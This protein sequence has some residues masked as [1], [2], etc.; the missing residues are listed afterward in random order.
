[1]CG[2][3]MEI[4]FGGATETRGETSSLRCRARRQKGG[5]Q[6]RRY[7]GGA[8]T[9]LTASSHLQSIE[10]YARLWASCDWLRD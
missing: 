10:D 2:L 4:D 5:R 7:R 9:H 8:A 3:Q 1:M 6:H